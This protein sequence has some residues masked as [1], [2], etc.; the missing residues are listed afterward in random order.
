MPRTKFLPQ[1]R[2]NKIFDSHTLQSSVLRKIES[3]QVVCKQQLL[4]SRLYYASIIGFIELNATKNTVTSALPNANGPIHLGHMLEQ[5][6]TDI[7]SD[8][9]I[10]GQQSNLCAP[11]IHMARSIKLKVEAESTTPEELVE[12]VD[13]TPSGLEKFNLFR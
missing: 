10:N 4:K 2:V 5:I 13:K 1:V 7:R 8:I 11:T 3:P 9:K 12:K 6:Q